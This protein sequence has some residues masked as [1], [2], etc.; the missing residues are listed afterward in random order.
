[1]EERPIQVAIIEDDPRIRQLL[2]LIV[3]GSPGFYCHQDFEDCE[4]AIPALIANT[5][6]LVLLDVDLPKM[7][8]IEGL[9]ELLKVLPNL[10]VVM[11]TVHED[12][13][14]V[15]NAL[16]AGAVGYLVKGLPPDQL[17]LALKEAHKGG[18]PMSATIARKV[19]RHFHGGTSNPLSGR[20]SEVLKLL[21][22]GENYKT[23][24][25]KLFISSNTVKAHIKKIYF[26]L[27]V[28]TRAEAVAKAIQKRI[29]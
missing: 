21:C 2:Q 4:T 7:S 16:C 10:I 19:V 9:K 25:S 26:K 5:P 3:D 15:F 13:E 20:E 14:T 28:N 6:D 11:L 1:M 22:E 12:D 18:A 29:V 23:I 17:L 24:A 27:Q 8:G